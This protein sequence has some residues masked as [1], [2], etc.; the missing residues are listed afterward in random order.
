MN[1]V[2]N[3]EHPPRGEGIKFLILALIL[4]GTVVVI[5]LLRP[6]IFGHVVPAVLGED[7]A[8]PV[9]PVDEVIEE[10]IEETVDELDQAVDNIEQEVEETTEEIEQEVDEAA[11]EV[12]EEI[13]EEISESDDDLRRHTVAVGQTLTQIAREYDVTVDAI[14]EANDLANPNVVRVG[15]VLLIPNE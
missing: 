10:E 7:L 2:P 12:E 5:A 3:H 8:Q 9:T 6:Y 11:E 14:V 13:E 1:D 4:L 15:D